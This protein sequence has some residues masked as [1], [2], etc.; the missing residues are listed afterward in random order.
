MARP[1]QRAT[2]AALGKPRLGG[3]EGAHGLQTLILY[4]LSAWRPSPAPSR[5]DVARDDV[6]PDVGR[7]PWTLAALYSRVRCAPS[8][9]AVRASQSQCGTHGNC[10]W[11]WYD[12]AP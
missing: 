6:V 8:A 12:H 9:A 2:L 1:Y 10:L 4:D 11:R 7:G 3:V 5:D